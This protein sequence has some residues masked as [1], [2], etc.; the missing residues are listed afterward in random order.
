MKKVIIL[1][2]LG[3]F[4]IV[5]I[6]AGVNASLLR[7]DIRAKNGILNIND[8]KI[9]DSTARFSAWI[10][11]DNGIAS[12]QITARNDEA[13][14]IVLNVKMKPKSILHLTQNR[15]HIENAGIVDYWKGGKQEKIYLDVEYD[16][17]RKRGLVN[18]KGGNDEF[19]F[20]INDMIADFSLLEKTKKLT[21]KYRNVDRAIK[22]GYI[23]TEDCVESPLGVMGIHYVNPGLSD[24]LL[25][26]LHPEM[27]LYVPDNGKFKLIGVEYYIPAACVGAGEKP[28]VFGQEL[29][30]PMPGHSPGQPEHYDLHVWLFEPNPSGVFALFNPRLN[31]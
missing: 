29:D 13:K 11:K 16:I 7:Y 14:R 17:D 8:E 20:S 21:T 26:E 25:D 5:G 6:I 2:F 19:N 3:L 27:L 10:K 22:D 28:T 4:L 9:A 12:L 24:C 15:I 1:L 30:G 31:C 23:S 18:I